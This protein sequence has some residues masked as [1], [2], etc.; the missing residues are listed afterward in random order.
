MA[1]TK[2]MAFGGRAAGIMAG[3]NR[4]MQQQQG[5]PGVMPAGINPVQAQAGKPTPDQIGAPPPGTA[6]ARSGPIGAPPPTLPQTG[7]PGP[8]PRPPIGAPAP[9][10]QQQP[11]GI[12][13]P[14]PQQQ[15]GQA[16]QVGQT[17]GPTVGA[18]NMPQRPGLGG[19]PMIQNARPMKKGGKVK[20]TTA[21][22]TSSASKRGDGIA[23]RG[24]TKGRMV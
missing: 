20:T 19:N 18:P 9:T 5:T 15:G 13:R 23:Q 14:M 10:L 12:G 11:A 2:R 22:K 16:V 4:G 17:G 21:T 8:M 1:K 3:R 24:K 7:G 6:Q